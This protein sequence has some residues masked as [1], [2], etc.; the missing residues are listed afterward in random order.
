MTLAA[1]SLD[2]KY[3]AWSGEV[4]MTG[5]QA[6]VRLPMMQQLRDEAAG[7]DTACMISGYRGSPLGNFDRALWQARPFIEKHGVHFQPGVNEDTA[8][9]ALWGTQQVGLFPGAKHDG[10]FAIWY[11]KGPGVDRTIDVFKHANLAGTASHGGVLALAGDDH[12]CASSTTAHQSEFDFVS[13]TMPVINPAGVQEFLDYGLHGW[14]LSRYAGLWVGFICIAET[15]DSSAIVLVDPHRVSI[16][17]P[18]DH[19]LPAGGLNIRWPDTPLAQE[20]RLLEHKL[21]AARAYAR[22]N[23]LD[24]SVIDGPGRRLGIVT[25][26][27]SYLDVR[28]ALD[29]LGID[30]GAARRLGLALYKVG[31]SWPLEPDGIR[32][33]AGGL[34]EILVVEEKRGF[35][36]DQ[37]KEILYNIPAAERPRVIGKCDEEGRPL[38]RASGELDPSGVAQTLAARLL[39]LGADEGIEARLAHLRTRWAE[40]GAGEPAAMER[41]P[42]FCSGCPHNS[43]T[44]VPEGSRALSGIGCHYMAQWMDRETDTYTHMGGE[45]ANWIGQAPFTETEHIFQNI[46]D[47]TYFH[48]GILAIR[49]AVAANVNMTYKILYNDA[50]AMTGG[51]PM[52]GP[53]SVQRVT[54]QVQAEGVGRIAVV[55]DQPEKYPF[56]GQFADGVTI[57]HRDELDQVQRDLRQWEGVSA[58]VYDQMCATEKRRRRKRGLLEDPD[59]RVIINPDVC[60]GCGDCGVQ[61]NCLSVVPLE[62]E[63]G[64]K[65][66]ID[67][68]ACNKDFSCIKG[69]C[70]S[71]VLVKGGKRRAGASDGVS[72]RPIAALPEPTRPGCTEPYGILLAGVGGTG[73]VTLAALLG[74]AARLEG[75]GATVLDKAGLAQKYGAVTSHIRIAERPEDLHAVRIAV[76]GAR[77]LL[78]IDRVVA[79][80]REAVTRLDK[81]ASHA[82]VNGGPI[83]TGDF[84][85]APDLEFPGAQLEGVVGAAA[86]T[87]DVVDA[88]RLATALVGDAVYTNLFLLGY[89]YQRGLVPLG[90][91]ALERAVTLNGVA[92]E[93]NLRAFRWGRAAAHDADAVAAAAAET[94]TL[95]REPQAQGLDALVERCASDL[96]AYQNTALATRYR[97]LVSRAREAERARAPGREGFG[98]AV[99]RAYHKLLAYK[100]EYEVAR[101]YTDGRFR[102]QVEA[103]FEGSVGLRF[104]MAPPLFAGRDP[105]T[106]HL[107]KRL[108]GPWMLSA[109]RLLAPFK[110]LRGTPLDLFGYSAERRRERAL[111]GEYEASVETLIAGLES[112]NHGLAVEIAE[113][114]L[115]M[116]GFG[117]VKEANIAC[118]KEREAELLA[119]FRAPVPQ[120]SAAE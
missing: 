100:D 88:T 61:S 91:E 21:D 41:V 28:Q 96:R 44:K 18:E 29:D 70:P 47:G 56:D 48:S 35:I 78:G 15:V 112:D 7:L 55:T 105:T 40:S 102:R 22:A 23:G 111:I 120:V 103:E 72:E 27:K 11:G 71:F 38:L 31:M 116:R 101:L 26:G 115:A 75:K 4:Y 97:A 89:A 25:T 20:E 13:A 52:D 113:V 109:F 36:E 80:S 94:G 84:T 74:T 10:V 45:G 2:D 53:L 30:E 108:Y 99:A 49:A 77:L 98:E 16:V 63:F 5:T 93:A 119:A 66:A 3:A 58:I 118:A 33:F 42:Y 57:H 60:E 6:L 51:Q 104:S 37:I 76:G 24:R 62:T 79:A 8:A 117:H 12:V 39:R 83:T 85:R 67:Q 86:R 43:S 34:D 17:T 107:K 82:V 46:G 90:A 81:S 73:I 9:T 1:V 92:V 14:G 50:V 110:C 59:W 69:F 68:S 106:G 54:C 114:P 65:R 87:L 64:R 32:R 19:E 95:P